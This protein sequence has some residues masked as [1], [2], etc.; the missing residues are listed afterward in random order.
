M[1][2]SAVPATVPLRVPWATVGTAVAVAGFVTLWSQAVPAW[3]DS[4]LTIRLVQLA[5]A[6]SAAYVLDDAAA[7]L[8]NVAPRPLWR[9]R[10][11][12]LIIGLGA[13]AI[14]W[15]IVLLG[16]RRQPEVI[17]RAL[18]IEIA[19]LVL[20]ALAAG[21]VLAMRG[22]PEPGNQVAVAVPLAG[23]GALI[24]GGMLGYDL[25][26]GGLGSELTG[27]AGAWAGVGGI[28]FALILWASRDKPA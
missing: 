20:V 28:A 10:G 21:A 14:S 17:L 26:I 27:K 3:A 23:V 11:F 5:L 13:I 1:T 8:T 19:V 6:A 18:T 2:V 4:T 25:F 9:H 22:E 24:I 15:A 7:T 12:G 16:L